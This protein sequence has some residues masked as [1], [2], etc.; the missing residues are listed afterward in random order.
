MDCELVLR[1]RALVR[2]VPHRRYAAPPPPPFRCP[3]QH[4]PPPAGLP[5]LYLAIRYMWRRL[6]FD[7]SSLLPRDAGW[8]KT[9]RGGMWA[10]ARCRLSDARIPSLLLL[11][12]LVACF[13]GAILARPFGHGNVE[14]PLLMVVGY[15]G[16][17]AL[18]FL[19][20]ALWLVDAGRLALDVLVK[21]CRRS[22]TPYLNAIGNS[23][24]SKV[25]H[26][27]TAP[28]PTPPPPPTHI[29]T[30][31]SS[32]RPQPGCRPSLF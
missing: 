32:G 23:I 22:R 4:L 8:F 29:S 10:L 15:N 26:P 21:Q 12:V 19:I 30:S 28:T 24:A 14:P 1:V 27:E 5:F 3:P 20:V 6:C 17:G 16:F 25:R 11:S 13:G 31:S 18:L 9:M 7:T 2:Y